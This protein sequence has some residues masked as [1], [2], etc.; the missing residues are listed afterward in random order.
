LI[1]A[2][3]RVRDAKLVSGPGHGLNEAALE[4]IKSFRFRPAE[5]D[6]RPVAVRIPF[7]YNFL[8]KAD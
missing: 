3:G 5:V 8:L 7:T 4:A 6:G 1:D 2:E